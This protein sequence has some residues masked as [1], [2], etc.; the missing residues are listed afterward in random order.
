MYI[1]KKGAFLR[2]CAAA[3]INGTITLI[4][5]LIAPMGLLAVIVNTLLI[6]VSTFVVCSF[7]D[8]VI[9]WLSRGTLANNSRQVYGM[10]H[11]ESSQQIERRRDD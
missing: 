7:G 8:N 3:A 6:T 1:S 10:S 2:N 4:I 11:R 9:M 5:L